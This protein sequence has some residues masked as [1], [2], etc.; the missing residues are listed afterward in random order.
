MTQR[1]ISFVTVGARHMVT[2]CFVRICIVKDS[3]SICRVLRR[4]T[5]LRDGTAISV[6]K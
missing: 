4:A 5:C 3:G 6:R 2:W 1:R